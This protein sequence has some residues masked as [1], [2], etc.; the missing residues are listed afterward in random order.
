VIVDRPYRSHT[1]LAALERNRAQPARTLPAGRDWHNRLSEIQVEK[2]DEL[3]RL[4]AL[5][6]LATHGALDLAEVLGLDGELKIVRNRLGTKL[7]A[8]LCGATRSPE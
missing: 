8:N 5:L 1:E 7:D 4:R 3:T 6:V 2:P